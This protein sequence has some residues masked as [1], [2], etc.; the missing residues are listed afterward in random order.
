MPNPTTLAAADESP[1]TKII[2]FAGRKQ[3][4]KSTL[5][6][7]LAH[8]A[9]ELFGP[10]RYRCGVW[11][12]STPV[13]VL[14]TGFANELKEL[15]VNVLGLTRDQ[16]YGTDDQKNTSTPYQWGNLPH[17][18]RLLTDAR[19]RRQVSAYIV[20]DTGPAPRGNMTAREVLQEVGTGIFRRMDPDVW[21]KATLRRIEHEAPDIAVVADARFP[22]EVEAVQKVGG[23]VV[24]LLRRVADDQH[25]SETAL[26]W[27]AENQFD[28]VLDNRNM[29]L[30]QQNDALVQILKGWGWCR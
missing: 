25:A 7:F 28:A 19:T 11:T 1:R 22:N 12:K 5:A 24:Y 14:V 4:G 8:N 13:V 30:G 20:T 23:K 6:N 2:A 10:P 3:A 27:F 17:Y 15:C 16:C 26:D 9:D 21:V 18:E 29:N